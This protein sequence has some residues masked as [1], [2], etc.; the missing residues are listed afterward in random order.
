MSEVTQAVFLSYASQDAAAAKRICEALRAAGI[1]IW[2]DQSE[3]TGG[4]AWDRKIRGQI[5]SCTLFLPVI[6]AATQARREGY[7]RIEWKLA[8]QRTHAMAEAKAF[9]LPVVI[10]ATRDAEAHVPPE[11][12]S[13]QWTRLP[14]G[15]T[16]AAFCSLVNS[17][18]TG[19]SAPRAFP[20]VSP[21]PTAR[22]TRP[23]RTPSLSPCAPLLP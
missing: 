5:A 8:A 9:L 20:P 15:E 11:F 3:L 7:F 14:A 12:K 4:D 6:S 19:S 2:F 17:L 18:L 10:D 16:S 1:V 13:V 22:N 21:A 23:W